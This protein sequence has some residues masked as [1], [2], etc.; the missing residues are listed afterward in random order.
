M[1]KSVYEFN[2]NRNQFKYD[3]S[4]EVKMFKEEVREFYEA[5]TLAE[6]V[7]AIVDCYYVKTGTQM[8][9]AYNNKPL[10]LPYVDS[11]GLMYNILLDEVKDE[12]KLNDII[13]KATDIVCKANE[14]KGSKLVDGKVSKDGFNIPVTK[15]IED[16][17]K[18]VLNE[19][20]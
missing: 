2:K 13:L 19:Y 7:D 11:T 17:I 14:L 20:K 5:N 6:R 10:E 8:K 15:Q 1:Y 18:D 4:L 12:Q 3:A 16:M 9:L